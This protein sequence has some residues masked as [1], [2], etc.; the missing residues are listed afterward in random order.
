MSAMSTIH[1]RLMDVGY[2]E[3]GTWGEGP[4]ASVP[5]AKRMRFASAQTMGDERSNFLRSVAINNV[6]EEQRRQD[7]RLRVA[8]ANQAFAALTPEQK[9]AYAPK[10][11]QGLFSPSAPTGEYTQGQGAGGKIVGDNT[12]GVTK[13]NFMQQYQNSPAGRVQAPLSLKSRLM[14]GMPAEDRP[15]PVP[16][17]VQV[18]QIRAQGDVEAA[19]VAAEG[20]RPTLAQTLIEGAGRFIGGAKDAYLENRKLAET[21]RH[22]RATET[23]TANAT[24]SRAST[25]MAQI[26]AR[27]DQVAA[28]RMR[29]Q[30]PKPLT[31]AQLV[32]LEVSLINSDAY[33]ALPPEQKN[34]FRRSLGM[35]EAKFNADGMIIGYV[36]GNRSAPAAGTSNGTEDL[37]ARM[38]PAATQPAPTSSPGT[39]PAIDSGS[40][41]PAD[42]EAIK[43]AAEGGNRQ[44]SYKASDLKPGDKPGMFVHPDGHVYRKVEGGYELVQ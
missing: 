32:P 40:V 26:K 23:N 16:E 28:D 13:A 39:R 20:K 15:A 31:P 7:N 44:S 14:L 33:A 8:Q 19:R 11:P 37:A 41:R 3:G 9:M 27:Q 34:E 42:E 21:E 4:V 1:D 2:G 17:A 18:A 24:N 10:E 12:A 5:L 6:V 22:N 25:A 29:N 30:Q 43:K 38:L 35:P 36:E